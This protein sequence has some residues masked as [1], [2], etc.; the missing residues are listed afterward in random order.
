MGQRRQDQKERKEE[1]GRS[2]STS[3]FL[4]PLKEETFWHLEQKENKRETY[5]E[6]TR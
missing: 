1:K 6:E 5:E 2:C 3:L 4:S